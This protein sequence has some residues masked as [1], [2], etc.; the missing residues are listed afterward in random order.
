MESSYLLKLTAA[1]Q[2]SLAQHPY[3]S[4][5]LLAAAIHEH[6]AQI[7]YMLQAYFPKEKV[8][9]VAVIPG[10]IS[11]G[12]SGVAGIQLEFVKEEFNMCSAID[13]VIKDK[14]AISVTVDSVAGEL[15]LKGESW[16]EL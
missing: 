5:E 7:G 10:S 16:P 8:S 15:L 14:M 6:A 4:T 9:N 1:Q 11:V 2:Q 13:S 3:I 12:E